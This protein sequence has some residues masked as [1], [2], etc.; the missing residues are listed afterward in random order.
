[1]NVPEALV[2][3]VVPAE[4][5]AVADRSTGVA[6]DMAG[7]VKAVV[8]GVKSA[9]YSNCGLARVTY[10]PQAAK[11]LNETE[12]TLR[13]GLRT[14]ICVLLS[15][16]EIVAESDPNLTPEMLIRFVPVTFTLVPPEVA[17]IVG[18][19]FVRVGGEQVLE[20][21]VTDGSVGRTAP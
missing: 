13:A 20:S 3:V 8:V 9:R 10:P 15:N 4:F 5:L 6:T 19:M 1:V 21:V 2:R 11:T 17:P 14:V 18:S 7:A 12:P 16:E